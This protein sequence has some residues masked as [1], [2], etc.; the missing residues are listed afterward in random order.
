M[1]LLDEVIDKNLKSLNDMEVTK[2]NEDTYKTLANVTT[3]LL[4]KKCELEKIKSSNEIEQ[5]KM[6]VDS[7]IKKKENNTKRIEAGGKLALGLG[8]VAM[9][10][11][12]LVMSLKIDDLG[13]I[14]TSKSGNMILSAISKL[15]P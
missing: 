13:S 8:Y 5:L 3:N 7:K 15:K 12:G 2:E 9:L 10:G 1:E 4:D 6:E 11:V 14:I